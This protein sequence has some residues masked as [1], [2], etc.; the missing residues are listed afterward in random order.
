MI[1]HPPRERP[2]RLGV[3][4]LVRLLARG[5]MAEV[6]RARHVGPAP[7][8]RGIAVKVLSPELA[9]LPHYLDAFRHEVRAAAS[10][11]HPGVA[12]VVDHGVV[13]DAAAD[14][15]SGALEPGAPWLAM[16]LADGGT[17]RDHC[18]AMPW[19]EARATLDTL[20]DALAH[21]HAQGLLHR[22]IKPSNALCGGWRPGW[23]WADFGLAWA[24]HGGGR[25]PLAGRAAGTP[26]YMPPEQFSGQAAD[27]TIPSDLYALG[28]TAWSL[29]CGAPPYAGAGLADLPLAHGSWPLP[30]LTPAV[31]VP[32]EL[33]GWLQQLLAKAPEHRFARAAGAQAALAA[34]GPATSP[35]PVRT[36]PSGAAE[37]TVTVTMSTPPRDAESRTTTRTVPT[38]RP[39]GPQP[40]PV[41]PPAPPPTLPV[42]LGGTGLGIF[43]L[44]RCPLVGRQAHRRQLWDHLGAAIRDQRARAVLLEGPAGCGKSRLAQ[45]L[46]EAS[47]AV[48][49]AT[50]LR[51]HFAAGVDGGGL[52]AMLARTLRVA[53]RPPEERRARTTAW[54]QH[55]GGAAPDEL[56]AIL[57]VLDP[58]AQLPRRRQD[59]RAPVVRRLIERQASRL[60]VVVWLD[61][62]PFAAEGLTIVRQLL[63]GQRL[64]GVPVLVVMTA[65]TEDL[66][67]RPVEGRD[68]D[69]LV[70]RPDVHRL[71]VGPLDPTHAATLVQHL[72][73]LRSDLAARLAERCGG[74]PLFAVQLVRDWV[75]RGL[76]IAAPGGFR[77]AEGA[78]VTVPEDLYG[79]WDGRVA[80]A[81]E[82]LEAPALW[83]MELLAT[84]GTSPVAMAEW[85]G[86]T[87]ACGAT[88]DP[89]LAWML[90]R[91]LATRPHDGSIA[92]AHPILAEALLRHAHRHGRLA[93]HHRTCAGVIPAG[94][95]GRR[96]RHLL[97]AHRHDEALTE[98]T[99]GL[100]DALDRQQLAA[101]ESVDALR[102]LAAAEAPGRTATILEGQ[103]LSA[104]LAVSRG[105]VEPAAVAIETALG[106]ASPWPSLH[107]EALAVATLVAYR[108]GQ[109]D[110][111]WNRSNAGVD[112][113]RASGRTDVI[114]RCIEIRARALA[115]R[116]R[117]DDANAS[118]TR[119]GDLYDT[120]GDPVGA[121][122]C[123][124]GQ[125]MVAM[126]RS[127]AEEARLHVDQGHRLLR[128]AGARAEEGVAMNMLGEVHRMRGDLAAAE[129]SYQD[130]LRRHTQQGSIGGA[131]ASQLNLAIAQLLQDRYLEAQQTAEAVVE[132]MRAQGANLLLGAGHLIRLACTAGLG[133]W[134]RWSACLADAQDVLGAT[135]FVHPDLE[136]VALR[137]AHLADEAGHTELGDQARQIATAQRL[138]LG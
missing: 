105:R 58:D 17:L 11:D 52:E 2:P 127:R 111:V 137:A 98:L 59:A 9:G 21:V 49:A 50:D 47:H 79:V 55:H 13:D 100:R 122:L 29:I 69:A 8:D 15:S 25:G 90:D 78:A 42:H 40:L 77:L 113:G 68:V 39:Q 89:A 51:A 93:A 133:R 12:M 123:R 85:R 124:L 4:E 41:A 76:L 44:R 18:G 99:A 30:R 20:L 28:C 73:G 121:G 26:A 130:A 32:A 94:R 88:P 43:G 19:P 82:E 16:E 84:L 86:A 120:L 103:I 54:L 81:R 75:D 118:Y 56:A 22:D 91:G 31:A 46:C 110:R 131:M 71:P 61:D 109:L 114:A 83:A 53:D 126:A 96:G 134:R 102:R 6:Y 33:E 65:R 119:A 36:V 128:S 108:A 95:H 125:C 24:V 136:L 135:G 14:A 35:P 72:L 62:V 1:G 48:G 80:R 57:E 92:L 107:A 45:W 10:I 117:L 5:G 138:A 97:E 66:A 27:L 37:A 104:R 3:F 64:A 101:A 60:P 63:E 106:Q 132:G 38:P 87:Q 34:L 7:S 67:D 70:R 116:G 129:A 115:D 112:V 23:K 74:N